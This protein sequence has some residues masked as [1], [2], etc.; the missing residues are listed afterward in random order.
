MQLAVVIGFAILV[1]LAVL[2][3]LWSVWPAW[4]KAL[5]AVGVLGFA[6]FGYDAVR[7]LG[8]LPSHDVLPAR[9]LLLGAAVDEPAGRQS[10]SIY[11]WVS[12]IV[13]G[14]TGLAPRAYRVKYTKR[15]HEEVDKGVRRA[16]D[17]VAQMG[18]S[19]NKLSGNRTGLGWLKPGADE[20]EV[21]IGDL[22]VPQLPEK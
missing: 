9:F 14:R 17:G 19:E 21:R 13:E 22:P 2:A 4:S 11:L 1:A 10:G 16:K 18:T 5:L 6:F 8:G 20:Q 7:E 15:L 12:E 3:L